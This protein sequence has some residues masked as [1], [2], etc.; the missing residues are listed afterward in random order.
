ME[1]I[2][3]DLFEMQDTTY[4]EF[5]SKLMPNIEFE[6]VIGVRT[7]Q[8]RKYGKELAK[9][10]CA[11]DFLRELPHTYYE[12]N[13]LHG[14][15]LNETIKD[16]NEYLVKLEEFLPY[17]DNWATCDMLSPKIFKKHLPLVYEKIK[18][19]IKS[20]D[21]YTVRFAIV[22]LLGFYLDDAFQPEM[23]Q[24]VA[25]VCLDDYYIKMAVAWYFSIALIK[26]YE[27][28]IK[29]IE[30]PVLDAWTHN[31]AIQKAIESRR[32]SEEI[33]SYL[34]GLKLVQKR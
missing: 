4:R 16:I 13:N 27:Y 9:K 28:T 34:R 6:K 8:L 1:Q 10:D 7:P 2:T 12:E 32:I 22:T 14:I 5:H 25:D 20:D 19:W 26:Q 15:M 29:Y 30:N 3:K 21:I 18:K 24:M 11:N 33:K 17:I 31:K 23:L